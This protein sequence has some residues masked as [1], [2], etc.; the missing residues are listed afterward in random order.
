MKYKINVLRL[1]VTSWPP[2]S[3]H[4]NIEIN[5]QI[6]QVNQPK[7]LLYVDYWLD[8]NKFCSHNDSSN[9]GTRW[10][11]FRPRS[12]RS[13]TT[14]PKTR[15]KWFIQTTIS[16]FVDKKFVL[17]YDCVCICCLKR[18]AFP[19]D[20]LPNLVKSETLG[21]FLMC[22]QFITSK[23]NRLCSSSIFDANL[24]EIK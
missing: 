11:G 12:Y 3:K 23:Y 14:P 6:S 2:K 1:P 7:L 16:R 8:M 22:K 13:S 9:F 21:V 19:K 5:L 4:N 24:S 15:D 10:I 20:K 17:L 18:Q